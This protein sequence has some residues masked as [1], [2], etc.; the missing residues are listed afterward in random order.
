MRLASYTPV[1]FLV[2]RPWL[3]LGCGDDDDSTSTT[4]GSGAKPARAR[5]PAKAATPS[6]AGST[7][8]TGRRRTASCRR[9]AACTGSRRPERPSTP[10]CA[11][12]QAKA[13]DDFTASSRKERPSGFVLLN[14]AP[15]RASASNSPACYPARAD[16]S[17]ALA[18]CLTCSVQSGRVRGGYDSTRRAKSAGP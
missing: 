12:T 10:S 14:V 2:W 1:A 5:Q 13:G 6:A 18:E 11:A 3:P 17:R 8:M 4:G 7:E 9:L 16:D 15:T